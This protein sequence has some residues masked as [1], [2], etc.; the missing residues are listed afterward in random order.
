MA[1]GDFG[2]RHSRWRTWLRVHT[3]NV[4][5]YR[6]GLTVPKARDCG[7][8]EWHNAGDGM[9]ACYHCKVERPSAAAS[10]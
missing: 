1:P 2:L 10:N 6:L 9:E 8:H 7:N 4:L 5:Y 3:P